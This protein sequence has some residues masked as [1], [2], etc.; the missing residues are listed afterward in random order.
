VS[1]KETKVVQRPGPK[2]PPP[3][4]PNVYDNRGLGPEVEK[5]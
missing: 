1:D 2:L 5:R 3:N 4:L